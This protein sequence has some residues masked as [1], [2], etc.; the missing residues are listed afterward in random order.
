MEDKEL[1]EKIAKELFG[2]WKEAKSAC[3]ENWDDQDFESLPDKH[4]HEYYLTVARI[5]EY[6]EQVGYR[7]IG[8]KNEHLGI[9][10]VLS[11]KKALQD[12]IDDAD[13][14]AEV[15]FI[16]TDRSWEILGW[17]KK[18]IITATQKQR[19]ADVKWYSTLRESGK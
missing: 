8:G 18:L 2:I 19:D 10:P 3:A 11:E 6:V 17:A 13:C 15:N 12:I 14:N 1:K 16:R 7:K 5:I 4:K 9:P